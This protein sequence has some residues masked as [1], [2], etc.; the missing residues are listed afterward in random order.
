MEN[1]NKKCSI[2]KHKEVNAI[3]Y[4]QECNKYMCNKCFNHHQ[5]LFED[6]HIYN[7][8][9]DINEIFI[10]ICKE[11]N[12]S[13]KLQYFCKDHNILCCAN[14]IVQI[15]GKGN[16]QHKNCNICFIE[17]I[18]EEKKNKLNE[19]IKYLED[20]SIK[21]EDSI[22]ELKIMFE[23]INESKEKLKLKIQKIF[24]NI[25]T[26][27]NEREDEILLEVDDKFKDLYGNE[28]IIKEGEKLPNKIKLSLEKGKLIN[29]EWNDNNKLSS[30]I[31]NCINI[32][33]NI[34]NINIINENIK[35]YKINNDIKIDFDLE[36][37][38]FDNFIYTIKSFGIL[39]ASNDLDSLI[40]KNKDDLNKFSNLLSKKI[41]IKKMKLLY[42]AS[43]DGLNLNNLRDK[44]N[45]KSNLIFLFLIGNTRIFGSFISS[46][47]EV[48]HQTY[49][50]DE[51]AFVFS[52]NNNKIYEILI[53]QY[54]IYF[55]NGYTVLIGNNWN[56]NG[57]WI[58]SGKFNEKLLTEPKI[59]D[60]QKNYE[61]TEGKNEFNELEIFE[62]NQNIN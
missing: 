49:T 41:K 31:N 29:N 5:E 61:L 16:G 42:R 62:I 2:T 48:Q 6:H 10:N 4:C 30:I 43:K 32:E 39:Y 12:H 50:K 60:F 25:R 40:L 15:E 45:N 24:T 34:K 58:N 36:N 44:I 21:L 46:K 23:K 19:N 56:G 9:K 14:C 1:N 53:P 57:F 22:K 27:L 17:N 7:L 8:D 54:A 59:Y 37:E 28:N 20:L 18:K 35:N 38:Y 13:N 55:Y 52:L 47:I 11:Q 3:S 51:N 26:I 33:D